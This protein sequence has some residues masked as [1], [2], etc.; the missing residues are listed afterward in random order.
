MKIMTLNIWG[1]Y[2]SAPLREFIAANKGIDIFCLQEVYHKA[3]GKIS[4]DD[5]KVE[6]EIFAML[7]ELLPNHKGFFRP[8]VDGTYGIALFVKQGILIEGEGVIDIHNDPSYP[9]HGPAHSRILQWIKIEDQTQSYCIM[10]VHGLWNG[11]GKTDTPPRLAQSQK[12]RDFMDQ[13][14][15]PIILCG[16][17]NLR[18]DT[19]SL[20]ILAKGMQNWVEKT[21][22]T[23]TRT[24]YYP[25]AEKFADYI[26]TS[27]EIEVRDFQVMTDEVSDHAPLLI[28]IL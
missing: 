20:Q 9:G 27:P 25:K 14:N 18:P 24:S 10:N 7:Q 22:V 3:T 4:D 21:G 12:I 1:G 15:A 11:Q 6:L 8:V 26:F 13:V 2:V 23:S 17:F 16:D 28:E 19:E 5:R